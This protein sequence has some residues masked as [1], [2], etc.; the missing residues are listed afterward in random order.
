MARIL[1]APWLA[2]LLGT[3]L[4]LIT[5]FVLMSRVTFAV[6]APEGKVALSAEND[7][8]WHFHNPE[9][10]QWLAQ[11]KTEKESLDQREQQLNELQIRLNSER[12]EIMAVT[13]TVYQLQSDFD[14]SV[15]RF[16]ADQVAD[17]KRQ[18]KVI[19][20]MSPDGAAK[21]MSEMPDN[22]TLPVL[23][24]LKTDQS[25]AILD[26][27]SQMGRPEAERA[28]RLTM[29]MRKVLSAPT[30]SASSTAKP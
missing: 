21:M 23:F 9:F 8:S 16:T 13:Q 27:M 7:P 18:S 17:A 5:T 19:A 30:N 28:A 10:N 6:P 29:Q 15:V 25:G 12:Q 2:A 4:Y 22:Q 3:I 20:N 11:I 26:A 1:Q 14:K 24:S